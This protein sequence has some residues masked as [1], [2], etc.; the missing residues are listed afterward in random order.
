MIYEFIGYKL[1]KAFH[2]PCIESVK[3]EKPKSGKP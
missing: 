3:H 2:I 1:Q